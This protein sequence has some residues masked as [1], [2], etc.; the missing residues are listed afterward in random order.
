MEV[1]G[2]AAV[3]VNCILIAQSGQVTRMFPQI[4]TTQA[5]L[6]IIVLEVK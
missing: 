4:T 3:V 2:V 6:L 5:I 1:M